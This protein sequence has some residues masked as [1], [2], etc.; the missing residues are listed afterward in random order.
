MTSGF[1]TDS[2][3]VRFTTDPRKRWTSGYVAYTNPRLTYSMPIISEITPRL[4]MGGVDPNLI[5]PEFFTDVVSLDPF[6]P[7]RV[8]HSLDSHLYVKME[9]SDKQDL[10][11]L[12]DLASWVHNRVIRGTVLVHCHMGLNR[13]GVV[14]A[15]SMVLG[16]WDADAAIDWIRE[17]RSKAALCNEVFVK[18]LLKESGKW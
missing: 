11:G 4:W 2:S 7:Y 15:A 1:E 12:Y 9:D 16:G 5:L 8:K 3:G 14:V 13:S 18:H 17:K 6:D 10:S